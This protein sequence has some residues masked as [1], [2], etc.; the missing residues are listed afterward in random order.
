MRK[1]I[2]ILLVLV[3][4]CCTGCFNNDNLQSSINSSSST[5]QNSSTSQESV[6]EE[7][8]SYIDISSSTL[9][10]DEQNEIDGLFYQNDLTMVSADPAC[11]YN[12]KDGYFY[13][14][15]TGDGG[16]NFNCYKSR[17][18]TDWEK[19]ASAFKQ[20]KDMN[21]QEKIATGLSATE[22]EDYKNNTWIKYLR[23]II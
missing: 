16:Q 15:G 7:S 6:I 18:L 19:L 14:Y 10:Q 21:E 22:F 2:T 5:S 4:I 8:L 3:V 17:N 1:I 13:L 9:S 12:E 23:I 11:V 20:A